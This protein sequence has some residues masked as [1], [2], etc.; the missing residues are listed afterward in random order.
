L[1]KLLYRK[2]FSLTQQ[3]ERAAVSR[4]SISSCRNKQG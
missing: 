1:K 3:M 4:T 2:N